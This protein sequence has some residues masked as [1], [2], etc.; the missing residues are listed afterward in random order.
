MQ[1]QAIVLE[2]YKQ[3]FIELLRSTKR[4]GIESLISWLCDETDFFTAPASTKTHGAFEGGLLVHSLSVYRVLNNFSKNI[5]NVKSDAIIISALLHD[6]CKTNFYTKQ[7]RNVKIPGERRW[8]EVE[9]YAIEDTLPLGHGEKS[10]Y[11]AMKHID[12][13]DEEAMA[14]RWHMGGYDDA[15][16]AYVGGMAQA[17][18]FTKYPLAAALSIADMYD[19]YIIDQRES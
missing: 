13:T 2:N 5:K 17:A 9:V 10:V 12:L 18:A 19:T 11:M 1:I 3:Q 14:I 15:A 16:R 4:K 7:I 8:E 6:L